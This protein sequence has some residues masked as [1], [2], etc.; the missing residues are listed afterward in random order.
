ML[1][2]LNFGNWVGRQVVTPEFMEQT[3]ISAEQSAKLKEIMLQR[4]QEQKKLQEEINALALQQAQLA[5]GLL[6]RPNI[7][8]D[9]LMDLIDKIGGLRTE[10]AKV[11]TRILI[12]IHEVLNSEQRQKASLIIAQEGRKRRLERQ[13]RRDPVR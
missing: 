3:G 8:V 5:R 12:D 7:E 2:A 4:E 9:E 6:S 1:R 13:Q 10:Q 11:N